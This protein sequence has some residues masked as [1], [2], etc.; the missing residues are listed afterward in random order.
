MAKKIKTLRGSVLDVIKKNGGCISVSDLISGVRLGGSF[1]GDIVGDVYDVLE[2][3]SQEG[4]IVWDNKRR[5]YQS[6]IYLL[7]DVADSIL[8]TIIATE[9]YKIQAI[10]KDT[11]SKVIDLINGHQKEDHIFVQIGV[12]LDDMRQTVRKCS[13][14]GH[15]DIGPI[16]P[17][18]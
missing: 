5:G 17:K 2:N 10:K 16:D 18:K 13:V 11:K 7:G 15:I 1:H 3:L 8:D 4:V 14:C 9:E 12:G 6:S